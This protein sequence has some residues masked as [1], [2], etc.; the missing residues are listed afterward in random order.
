MILYSETILAFNKRCL[1]LLRS[2]LSLRGFKVLRKRFEYNSYYYPLSVVSFEGTEIGRFSH[3]YMQIEMNRSL[4]HQADDRLLTE[5]LLHEF[6]HYL[7]SIRFPNA[8]AHGKEF[9]QIC[10]ELQLPKQISA[11]TMNLEQSFYRVNKEDRHLLEKIKKLLKLSSS[12]NSNEAELATLKANQLLLKYNIQNLGAEEEDE[13]CLIRLL[14]QKRKTAKLIAVYDILKHF[15]V[16]PV[17]SSG[18][19]SCC[20]EVF[21]SRTNIELAEY[22]AEFLD[23]EL[24]RLWKENKNKSKLSGLRAKNSFFRGIASGYDKKMR[25]MHRELNTLESK[26]LILVHKQLSEWTHKIYGR[27]SSSGS[28]QNYDPHAGELGRKAGTQLSVN[29]AVKNNPSSKRLF[30]GGRHG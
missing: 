9:H 12:D 14:P 13:M 15:I 24:E 10:N 7:T 17:I 8:S 18:N 23:Y 2:E 21:G 25:I 30:I 16:Y 11:S 29:Q 28:S 4:I 1:N 22:V 5:I 19:H 20:I 3:N 27:L 6:A 26:G